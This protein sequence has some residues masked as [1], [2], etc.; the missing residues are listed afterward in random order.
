MYSLYVELI[1]T[2]VSLP[3]LVMMGPPQ[4]MVYS[5]LYTCVHKVLSQRPGPECWLLQLQQHQQKGNPAEKCKM[6]FNTYLLKNVECRFIYL[7]IMFIMTMSPYRHRWVCCWSCIVRKVAASSEACT[8]CLF[9]LP[10][11]HPLDSTF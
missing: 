9:G 2:C 6:Q 8:Q 10:S 3:D 5:P 4:L 1:P 11:I 7:S